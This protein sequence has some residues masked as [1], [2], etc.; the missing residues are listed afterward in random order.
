[1][2][3]EKETEAA[4]QGFKVVD[5]RRFNPDGTEKAFASEPSAPPAESET[6]PSEKSPPPESPHQESNERL[7]DRK[8]GPQGITFADL[9]LSLAGSAQ[10]SLGIS[11]HPMSPPMEKDLEQAKQ[12]IDLLGILADKTRGNLTPEEDR[13]LEIVLAD[14]RIRYV[15]ECKKK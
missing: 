2:S 8:E 3:H 1:M 14:L 5:H 11:P 6:G 10:M 12:S 9:I 7:S 13:L 4:S 15:E